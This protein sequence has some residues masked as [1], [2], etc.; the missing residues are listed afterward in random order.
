MIYICNYLKKIMAW[1]GIIGLILIG[2][3]WTQQIIQIIKEKKSN[4]NFGFA[5]LYVIGSLSLVLYSLQINDLIFALLNCFALLMGEIG[6]FY[7]IK[8]NKKKKKK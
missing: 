2:I 4:L 3:G 1:L 6:L 5:L 8:Y 7:T